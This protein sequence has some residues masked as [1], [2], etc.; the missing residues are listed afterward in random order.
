MTI[1]PERIETRLY[2]LS[3][4]IDVAHEELVNAEKKYHT[5]KAVFEIAIARARIHIGTNNLKLRVGD[6]ADKAL[7]ECEQQWINLQTAEALVKAARANTNRV[8]TQVDIARSIGT[9][10]RASL[11]V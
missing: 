6:V 9:S 4:E 8:R 1:T 3:K 7:L 5:D 2:E 10:V 11:E